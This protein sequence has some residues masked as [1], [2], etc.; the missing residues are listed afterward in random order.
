MN[1]TKSNLSIQTLFYIMMSLL[2]VAIIIFGIGKLNDVTDVISE[3]ERIEVVNN[4]KERFE[5]CENDPLSKGTSYTFS[6]GN[7]KFNSVCLIG[8]DINTIESTYYGLSSLSQIYS[9]GDNLVFIKASLT[10]ID[11]VYYFDETGSFNVIDT[12]RADF[13]HPT[14]LCWKT[15]KDKLEIKIVC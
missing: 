5:K 4:L 11:G 2:F 7:S 3:Q 10:N 14:T 9:S 15:L 8:E 13:I 1:N 12:T 6:V